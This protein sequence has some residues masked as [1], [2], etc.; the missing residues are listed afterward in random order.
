MLPTE[1]NAREKKKKT[2]QKKE[3]YWMA[4]MKLLRLNVW[5]SIQTFFIIQLLC[6]FDSIF[7]VCVCVTFVL[8]EFG[9]E[10]CRESLFLH[11]VTSIKWNGATCFDVCQSVKQNMRGNSIFLLLVVWE[12]VNLR[13]HWD[14]NNATCDNIRIRLWMW[15]NVD[16]HWNSDSKKLK[17]AT[18][19]SNIFTQKKIMA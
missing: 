14:I 5:R 3:Y 17:V 15:M 19:K 18:T 10:W 13:V 6:I 1:S 7:F 11:F 16:G 12:E 4:N 9:S 8:D 2:Q